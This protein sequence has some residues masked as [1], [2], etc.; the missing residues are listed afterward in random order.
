MNI[1]KLRTKREKLDEKIRQAE[2]REREQK[3]R[4]LLKLARK[5]GLLRM[6]QPA[7]ETALANIAVTE[8]EPSSDTVAS[9]RTPARTPT[10]KVRPETA[11]E[12]PE[13]GWGLP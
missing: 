4:Q 7:L 13:N 2:Q 9:V 3:E 11:P 8:S 1:A 12:I 10:K 5:H 6:E